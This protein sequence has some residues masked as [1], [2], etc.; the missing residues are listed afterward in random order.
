LPALVSA[1]PHDPAERCRLFQRYLA[2]RAAEITSDNLAALQNAPGWERRRSEVRRQL[3]YMLGLDPL[4]AR[5]PLQARITGGFEGEGYRV[6]NIVFESMPGLYVTGNLYL[7]KSVAAPVP[8]VVYVC[9][10]SPGPVGAKVHYQYHGTWYARHGYAAFL[11]DTIEYGELPGIHHGLHN[12]G[13]WNWLSLGYTPAGPEV[14][15]AMRALDYLE[16]RREV[17]ARRAAI[18][19]V[20]GGGAITWYTAAVDERFQAVAPVCAT[21]TAEDQAAEDAVKENCD[22]IYFPNTYQLDFPAVAALI[23]PRPLRI[24]SA[25]RD[26]MFP[27]VGYHEVYQRARLLY[28]AAGAGE[29]IAED[30]QDAPHGDGLPLRQYARE[31]VVRWLGGASSAAVKDEGKPIEAARLRVLDRRPGDAINDSIQ[32]KFIH[33]AALRPPASLA[34]W[35]KRRAGLLAELRDEVF[36]GFPK[37]KAPFSLWRAKETGWTNL[38]ADSWNVEFTTEEGVRV[39]GQ[40]FVPRGPARARPVLIQV[41][42]A[43]DIVY[44]VDYDLI[45][46]ALGNHVVLVLHP[47]GVDCPVDNFRMATIKRTAALVGATLESMQVWDILRSVDFLAEEAKLPL[48]SVSVYGRGEM[49]ALALY[50]AA[51]E[52]RIMRVI[53]ED[54]PGSHWQGP[55]LLN[56]LRVTDLP[57]AAALLAPR[58]IVSLT[59]LPSAYRYTRRIF[60]LY[61]KQGGIREAGSLGKALRVWENQ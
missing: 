37:T 12:L 47:R 41:K 59:P 38:Y 9:G 58:E 4:P 54:P 23:A 35:K 25:R 31:W 32:T 24:L 50:A 52:P 53:V 28:E 39:T 36:R 55:A 7:P 43:A 8:A 22:C 10:H 2:R 17:D 6:E 20:S 21:W 51:F 60:G 56:V 46:P 33:T 42:G 30:D 13:M 16:T 49:G 40:L 48:E 45:L 19:G 57:E 34:A 14:W 3:L 15:N 5:T 1:Q 29:K 44:P 27:P 11:L 61:G 26:E 18:T